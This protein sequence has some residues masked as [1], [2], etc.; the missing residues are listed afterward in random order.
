[1]LFEK[2]TT[3]D[4]VTLMN[5]IRKRVSKGGFTES[6]IQVGYHTEGVSM[7]K[8]Q[9]SFVDLAACL[10]FGHTNG[11]YEKGKYQ[12]EYKFIVNGKSFDGDILDIVIL[13]DVTNK[14]NPEKWIFKLV[15]VFQSNKG[16]AD[17]SASFLLSKARPLNLHKIILSSFYSNKPR[18]NL[19]FTS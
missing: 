13:V 5:L 6:G 18:L 1:M 2:L 8:R 14:K 7:P 15:T 3:K 4:S 12:N 11:N 16:E 17:F 10:L 19:C 9:V